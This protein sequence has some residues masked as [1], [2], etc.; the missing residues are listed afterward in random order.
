VSDELESMWKMMAV[1]CFTEIFR[2]LRRETE[3]SHRTLQSTYPVPVQI[4][5]P[6]PPKHVT[7]VLTDQS[8]HSA[9]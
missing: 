4:L 7:E 2:K 9:R 1:A 5:G 6:E 8:L 3:K